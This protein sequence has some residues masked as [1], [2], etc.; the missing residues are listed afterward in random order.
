MN[1]T[2]LI[3]EYAQAFFDLAKEKNII[4]KII[5]GLESFE[6]TLKINTDLK[7]FFFSPLIPFEE[8]KGLLEISFPKQPVLA[9]HFIQVIIN[10]KRLGLLAAICRRLR[11]LDREQRDVVSIECSSAYPLNDTEKKLL[12][13][14]LSEYTG[15]K[16]IF[17]FQ[18]SP[19]LL[20]GIE[21]KFQDK[22]WSMNLV[23]QL[24]QLK[25]SM[26]G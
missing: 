7:K 11:K 23:N 12:T 25:H 3:Q 1:Q 17:S 9:S 14:Y 21:L 15:K 26:E 5:I 13:K 19:Q 20:A 18:T 8:K 24:Q 22:I 10:K 2:G 16:V 6:E 4:E